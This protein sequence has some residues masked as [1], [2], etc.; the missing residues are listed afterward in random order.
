MVTPSAMPRGMMVT[1]CIGS[2]W[3]RLAN[4]RV[5]GLVIG[6]DRFSSSVSSIDLRSAPISTLS[7]ASSKSYMVTCLRL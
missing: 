1:L 5:A 2:E 7:L 4:Q 6:G 3:S